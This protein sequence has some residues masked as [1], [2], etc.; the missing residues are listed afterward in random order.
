MPHNKRD[1]VA[2]SN[3]DREH[4]RH[5]LLIEWLIRRAT[6]VLWLIYNRKP[7]GQ[8]A[9]GFHITTA[10]GKPMKDPIVVPPLTSE[11]KV[12]ITINPIKPTGESD[13]D[14]DVSFSSSD[15][16]V[17]IE[18]QPDGRSAY[19]QTP[20]ES[21]SARITVSAPGY[22]EQPVDVTYAPPVKGELNVTIGQPESDLPT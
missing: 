10:G 21:G 15:P 8:L 4:H 6:R 18:E 14:V 3:R 16:S 11:Q 17:G 20:G 19:I 7:K 12:L 5:L 1:E 22:E 2:Q 9:I 13:P